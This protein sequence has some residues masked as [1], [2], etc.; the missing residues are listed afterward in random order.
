MAAAMPFS[1]GVV[2]GGATG[3]RQWQGSGCRSAPAGPGFKR[4]PA[5]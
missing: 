5:L 2:A 1:S 3:A 4:V